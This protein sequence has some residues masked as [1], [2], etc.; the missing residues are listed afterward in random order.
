MTVRKDERGVRNLC[1]SEHGQ[2]EHGQGELGPREH[3][4]GEPASPDGLLPTA[5]HLK[6]TASQAQRS[7]HSTQHSAL[8]FRLTSRRGITLLE[9][10]I[11]LAIV[12]VIVFIAIPTMNPSK[13]EATID[14]AKELLAYVHSQEQ[15]Y[16]GMH[17]VYA[18][19]SALASDPQLGEQFDQRFAGD[20]PEVNGI[21]FLGPQA[22]S[23]FYE[24]I[25]VLPDGSR[26]SVN[27]TG[28]IR[29]LQ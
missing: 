24:I 14:L 1:Q 18:P 29:A 13:D 17:G 27:S 11:V 26:Y 9:L 20:K 19:L 22:E 23:Q 2:G 10:A 25:A 16:Y 6:H 8:T 7:A 21:S 3:G 12:G 4:Q 28:E 15:K 5:T